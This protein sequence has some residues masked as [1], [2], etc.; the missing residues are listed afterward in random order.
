MERLAVLTKKK[1]KHQ[2]KK[3]YGAHYEKSGV[4]LEFSESEEKRLYFS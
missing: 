2:L 1:K 4:Y 3:L